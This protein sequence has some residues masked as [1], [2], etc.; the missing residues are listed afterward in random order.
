MAI[1]ITKMSTAD[2]KSI[3]KV[4]ATAGSGSGCTRRPRV[5][6]GWADGRVL[7]VVSM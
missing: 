5:V 2:I 7:A 4:R 3:N 1:G 6:Q